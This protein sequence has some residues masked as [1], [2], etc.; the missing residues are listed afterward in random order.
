MNILLSAI[1]I[2]HGLILLRVAETSE[3]QIPCNN[4]N[5]SDYRVHGTQNDQLEPSVSTQKY[6]E[7]LAKMYLS[8]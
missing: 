5:Y 7:I 1:F 6:P 4:N 3:Q 8:C 2:F